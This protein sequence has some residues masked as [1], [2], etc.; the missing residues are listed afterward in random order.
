MTV[1]ADP[2]TATLTATTVAVDPAAVPPIE[3]WAAAGGRVWSSPAGTLLT[4]DEAAV[5]APDVAAATVAAVAAVS[6]DVGAAAGTLPPG[7]GPVALGALPFDP[8]QRSALVIPRWS[9]R[10]VAGDAW[11]TVVGE[12]GEAPAADPGAVTALVKERAE[13]AASVPPDAFSLRSTMPHERWVALVADAIATIARG[14]LAKV[15]L[16][17]EVQ[18]EANRAFAL[19]DV[20]RRLLALHP[21][22]MVFALDGFLGASPE[23]LVSRRDDDVVSH[24]LAGT[25]ARSGDPDADARLA[26]TLLASGKD[27][28][29]HAVVVEAVAGALRDVCSDVSVP[30][31]PSIVLLRNVAHLGTRITGRVAAGDDA[32]DALTLA[33]LLHPTPAVAGTPTAAA[34]DF[35]AAHEQLERGRYAGPVGWVDANGDGE[36]AVG[37]RSATVDGARASLVAGVGVVAGSEPELELAETQLKLQA[38]LAALVRP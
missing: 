25:V 27:R 9:V 21:S 19:G 11:L 22:C 30:D 38:L 17:R 37:I 6:D 5:V 3:R 4:I 32:N 34:L 15:V 29:E 26:A 20:V 24:P 10:V 14:G 1:A 12:P 35:L 28:R 16:A 36:F 2:R 8:S 23:L 18:V 7:A 33:R 31:E 13:A